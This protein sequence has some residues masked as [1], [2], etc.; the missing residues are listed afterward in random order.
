MKFANAFLGT[1]LNGLTRR[2]ISPIASSLRYPQ[3]NEFR[4]LEDEI[5]TAGF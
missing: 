5:L 4:H 3:G 2:D 1:V